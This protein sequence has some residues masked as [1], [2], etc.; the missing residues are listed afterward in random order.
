MII[1]IDTNKIKKHVKTTASK[2]NEKC[3][4]IANNVN[5]LTRLAK[6]L[7]VTA[8]KIEKRCK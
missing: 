3:S 1:T 8:N 5:V 4:T 2:V 7:H 6:S